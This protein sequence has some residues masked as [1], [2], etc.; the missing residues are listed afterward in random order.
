L[1]APHSLF[2]RK[3]LE[4]RARRAQK[5]GAERF[6]FDC[7]LEELTG[8][9]GA[10][11]RRFERALD[12]GTP[13]HPALRAAL[14]AAGQVGSIDRADIDPGTETVTAPSKDY[15]LA[16]SALAMQW[17]NDLPGVL[18]QTKRLLKPDGLLLVAL[19]GGDTLF[20][21]RQSLAAAEDAIEGGVSPR[22][23]PFVE[24]RTLGALLQRAGFALPVTD[25]D[26]IT[27]RYPG[28]LE[29]MRDLRRMGAANALAERSRKPL[30]RETLFRAVEIYAERFAD[31]DG[32]VR[33][34]FEVL[35]M[36][37]W[38]PDPSQQQPLEPGSAKVRL[39]DALRAVEIPAGDKAGPKKN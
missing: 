12:I 29:L 31:A 2:D 10:V 34:T 19:V 21:L 20:E 13:D 4:I 1:N 16:V 3:L 22:V 26:R 24:I 5:T 15:D 11:T 27:V 18:A 38:A 32:R 35:W 39:A 28:A 7:A 8:R 9:L 23:S 37:G 25:T 17:L 36:S 14:A 30:R 6:L 33:A